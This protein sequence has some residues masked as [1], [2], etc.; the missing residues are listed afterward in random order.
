MCLTTNEKSEQISHFVVVC[1]AGRRAVGGPC[2]ARQSGNISPAAAPL[3]NLCPAPAGQVTPSARLT[4]AAHRLLNHRSS[5]SWMGKVILVTWS[6]CVRVP[7]VFSVP[8]IN[9][10]PSMFL[11]SPGLLLFAVTEVTKSTTKLSYSGDFI[12]SGR[13]A[14]LTVTL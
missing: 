7:C 1:L 2:C 14:V 11:L 8:L 12:Q 6:S 9:Y 5:A 13:P 10:D 4:T 3:C